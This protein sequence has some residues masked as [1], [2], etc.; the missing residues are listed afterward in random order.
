MWI[1]IGLL[2]AAG[3]FLFGLSCVIY[4]ALRYLILVLSMD[5][6]IL[7]EFKGQTKTMNKIASAGPIQEEKLKT[8][9][10]ARMAPTEGDFAPYS[11]E[12]A[13]INEQVEH[14]RRQGMTDEELDAFVR[15]A[16]GTDIGKPE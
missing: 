12:E 13:F 15:S 3:F 10:Q 4:V 11:E 5:S 1:L 8:F 9:I 2:V 14:L 16:V 6:A 7:H